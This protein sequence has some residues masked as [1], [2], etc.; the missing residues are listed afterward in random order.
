MNA[1]RAALSV[2]V[3]ICAGLEKY[4][5][6]FSATGDMVHRIAKVGDKHVE[7]WEIEQDAV[8]AQAKA[9]ALQAQA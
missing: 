9:K 8:I 6:A 7:Q 1:I 4:A 3:S 2:F 5:L